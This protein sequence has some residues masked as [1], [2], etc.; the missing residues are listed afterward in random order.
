LI[1]LAFE[2]PDD[3]LLLKRE[4]VPVDSVLARLP[5]Q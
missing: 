5:S 4:V 2:L 1:G 3:V